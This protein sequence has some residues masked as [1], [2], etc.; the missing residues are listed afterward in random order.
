[1]EKL[2]TVGE[3]AEL[4]KV[5]RSWIYERTRRDGPEIIPHFKVGKYLRF[6]PRDL[7]AFLNAKKFGSR[8]EGSAY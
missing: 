7:E 4:L 1:M 6:R 5:P 2:L 8:G 3:V